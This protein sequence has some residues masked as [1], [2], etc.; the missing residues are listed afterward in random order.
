M[1]HKTCNARKFS[2]KPEG[3]DA[4]FFMKN[5][6]SLKYSFNITSYVELPEAC[7]QV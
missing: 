4:D 3:L 5:F 2:R 7:A 6:M 1:N